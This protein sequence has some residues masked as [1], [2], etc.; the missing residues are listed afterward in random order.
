VPRDGEQIA[1]A[2]VEALG[3]RSGQLDV[4]LLVLATGTSSVW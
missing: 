3:D 1:V 2:R 4:L